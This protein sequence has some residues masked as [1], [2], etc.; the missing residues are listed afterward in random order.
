MQDLNLYKSLDA[1]D[2]Y[3]RPNLASGAAPDHENLPPRS[4]LGYQMPSMPKMPQMPSYSSGSGFSGFSST[5][6]EVPTA[7]NAGPG[8][9]SLQHNPADYGMTSSPSGTGFGS[10]HFHQ[11]A[12]P[13]FSTQSPR[14]VSRSQDLSGYGLGGHVS[15]QPVQATSAEAADPYQQAY[16]QQVN[17]AAYE[18]SGVLSSTADQAAAQPV[19]HSAYEQSLLTPANLV[20]SSGTKDASSDTALPGSQ[21]V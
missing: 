5:H 14:Q 6:N 13:Y 10:P 18:G 3:V 1:G 17:P 11:A 2:E 16:L 7:F 4:S 20:D 8:S 12:S 9:P 21:E 15:S 19:D